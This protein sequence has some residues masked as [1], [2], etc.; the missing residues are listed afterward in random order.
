MIWAAILLLTAIVM[1]LLL[2]PLWRAPRAA[3]PLQPELTVYRD[4]LAE[5]D[6][7]LARG[8]IDAESARTA[9][10]EIERRLLA[11]PAAESWREQSPAQRRRFAIVLG[12]VAIALAIFIYLELGR[13]D[14]GD[15]PLAARD[16][17]PDAGDVVPPALDPERVAIIEAEIDA[18]EGSLDE[19]PSQRDVWAAL[20][21]RLLE[22]SRLEPAVD[23][24]EQAIAQGADDRLTQS[25]YG[26]ALTLLDGGR[27]P[28]DA[29][30][31]FRRALAADPDDIP[32]TY[33]LAIRELQLGRADA[34]LKSLIEL[35]VRLPADASQRASLAAIIGEIAQNLGLDPATVR[36]T[37]PDLPA[38]PEGEDE[39]AFILSMVEGLAAR[40]EEQPDDLEGWR[41]LAHSWSVLG[42]WEKSAD[43]YAR[44]AV[45]APDDV[46]L[47]L[48]YA[49]AILAT[50]PEEDEGALPVAIA[51]PLAR[52]LTLRPDD[53]TGLYLS[54]LER[55]RAG[56][57]EAARGHWERLLTLLPPDAPQRA[58]I[59]AE[60]AALDG[61][62]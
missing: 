44:A 56:D 9:R 40:L 57:K 37:L 61:D 31:A 13:P 52:I 32:A 41:R 54:G 47:Q 22:L 2:R 26:V 5:L 20:G 36:E 23:A 46:E 34:A 1:G 14:L 42:E 38:I 7:D 43:A 58:K 11:L 39:A 6:A 3:A 55:A 62:D 29:E 21:H 8:A 27:V 15:Q 30:T 59:E 33:W 24:L 4:Q 35:E 60:L 50:V 45:I 19:N 49:L 51:E 18:L 48:D 28:P 53:P 25:R 12:I 16:L 17:P 10:L